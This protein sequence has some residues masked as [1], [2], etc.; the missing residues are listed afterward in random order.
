[1]STRPEF[2][3]RGI[4][5]VPTSSAN[6]IRMFGFLALAAVDVFSDKSDGSANDLFISVANE[7]ELLR[8]LTSR[9]RFLVVESGE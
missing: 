1:M 3:Y 6:I 2:Q 7:A 9:I 5:P 4:S 8:E